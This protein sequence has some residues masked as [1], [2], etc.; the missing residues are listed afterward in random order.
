MLFIDGADFHSID[1]AACTIPARLNDCISSLTDLLEHLILL[2]E[3]L[4]VNGGL[5][6][7]FYSR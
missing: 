4:L 2:I 7:L 6:V 1:L 5:T 3:A